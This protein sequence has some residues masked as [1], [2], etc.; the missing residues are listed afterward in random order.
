[1]VIES[2]VAPRKQTEVRG[3]VTGVQLLKAV[4]RDRPL[5]LGKSWKTSSAGTSRKSQ[6]LSANQKLGP[7]VLWNLPR[8]SLGPLKVIFHPGQ[9]PSQSNSKELAFRRATFSGL[10]AFLHLMLPL[11]LNLFQ[12]APTSL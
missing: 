2:A 7:S 4:L 10:A 8:A 12:T 11:A 5:K 1:M 9:V 3:A 6:L